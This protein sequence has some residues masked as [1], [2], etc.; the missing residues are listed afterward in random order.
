LL[1]PAA[2]KVEVGAAYRHD[3]GAVLGTRDTV[4]PNT[5]CA[6]DN[7]KYLQTAWTGVM[8]FAA[9]AAGDRSMTITSTAVDAATTPTLRG[10]FMRTC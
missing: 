5:C 6:S 3:P 7:V 8:P 9:D 2:F 10:A 4:E 1:A